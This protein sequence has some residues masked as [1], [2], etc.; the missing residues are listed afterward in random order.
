[1]IKLENVSKTYYMD[2]EPISAL[3]EINITVEEGDI[4]PLFIK[5]MQIILIV[6]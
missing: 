5:N 4:L 6:F 2:G 3:S 1:M